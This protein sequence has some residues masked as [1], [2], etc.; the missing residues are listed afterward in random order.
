VR[1]IIPAQAED[2]APG[3]GDGREQCEGREGKR[4]TRGSNRRTKRRELQRFQ[5]SG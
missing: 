3:R 5:I 2:V 4:G 1:G